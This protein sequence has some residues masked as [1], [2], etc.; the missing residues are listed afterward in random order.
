MDD[1][2]RAY[3][4]EKIPVTLSY[5]QAS[6]LLCM[7]L[8]GKDISRIEVLIFL[9]NSGI[10]LLTKMAIVCGFHQFTM[11]F[12]VYDLAIDC[13]TSSSKKHYGGIAC[14][15]VYFIQKKKSLYLHDLYLSKQ[16]IRSTLIVPK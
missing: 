14:F 9:S 10:Y 1:L 6:V 7:G 2:A 4:L 12:K 5:A 15:N 11:F 3:F 13:S 16:I 8:Q